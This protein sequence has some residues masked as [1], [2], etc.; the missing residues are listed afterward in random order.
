MSGVVDVVASDQAF[1]ALKDDGSVVTWGSG[2]FGGNSSAVASELQQD[3]VDVVASTSAFAARR[4]DGSVVVWGDQS[5]GGDA[6]S[7]QGLIQGG[8][9]RSMPMIRLFRRSK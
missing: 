7:V 1:A 2:L 5:A 8:V 6:T 4:S 9:E 3:V